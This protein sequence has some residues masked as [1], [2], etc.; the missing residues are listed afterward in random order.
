MAT[1]GR[2][3]NVLR[4]DKDGESFW[5]LNK[6]KYPG[7]TDLHLHFVDETVNV[8]MTYKGKKSHWEKVDRGITFGGLESHLDY[9]YSKVK[10]ALG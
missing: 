7:V 10:Q 3:G 2:G 6:S 1:H 4:T 8:A 5:L 9:M